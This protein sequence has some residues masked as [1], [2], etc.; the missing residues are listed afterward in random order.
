MT[1]YIQF[2]RQSG[3]HPIR[4]RRKELKLTLDGL[5][6]RLGRSGQTVW[7][8]ENGSRLPRRKDLPLIEKELGLS[9]AEVLNFKPLDNPK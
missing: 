1:A 2:G 5:G 6:A 9:P 7:R 3:M 8:W 4:K